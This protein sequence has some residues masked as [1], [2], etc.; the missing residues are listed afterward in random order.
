MVVLLNNGWLGMVKQWQKLFWDGNYSGTRLGD[1][2]DFALI[3]KAYRAEGFTV[4][5]PGEIHD[6]LGQAFDSGKTCVVDIH[7]DP[8]ED[9]L[10]MLPPN[11]DLKAISGRCPYPKGR[12][13]CR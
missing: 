2:P 13:V 1:D 10:P 5:R 9:A 4:E 3:A 11:P 6:A 8:E 12:C 7:V